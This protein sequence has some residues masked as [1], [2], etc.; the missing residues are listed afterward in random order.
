MQLTRLLPALLALFLSSPGLAQEWFHYINLEERFAVNLP[1]EPRVEEFTYISE[2]YSELPA[3]RYTVDH[4]DQQY[5]V[6]V[7]DMSGTDLTADNEKIRNLGRHEDELGGAIA[8]AATQ[9]RREGT[10]TLDAYNTLQYIPGH[11]LHVTLPDGRVNYAVIHLH[12][13][14]LYILEC[15]VPEGAA[16]PN[17][18]L[19]T[20]ELLDAEGYVPRYQFNSFPGFVPRIER[21]PHHVTEDQ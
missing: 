12:E 20:L 5:R 11:R 10:V 17:Y 19:E 18:V 6:T 2:Y 21:P 4:N 3:R 14:R 1:A 16:P 15:T 7:V 9:L 13:E 8:F